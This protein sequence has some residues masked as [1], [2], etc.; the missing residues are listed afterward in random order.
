[1]D[2]NDSKSRQSLNKINEN[3]KKKKLNITNKL[4]YKLFLSYSSRQWFQGEL[5]E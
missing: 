2:A 5:R 4:N 1:M 3:L